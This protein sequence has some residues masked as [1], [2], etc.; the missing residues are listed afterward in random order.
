MRLAAGAGPE[1]D[2]LRL[3]AQCDVEAVTTT[4]FETAMVQACGIAWSG[5]GSPPLAAV[6]ARYDG[7]DAVPGIQRADP[8]W[9]RADPTRV[10]LIGG[11]WLDVSAAE[12]DALVLLLNEH[13]NGDSVSFTRGRN[14]AQWYVS[15][16]PLPAVATASPQRLHGRVL[17]PDLATM[18]GMGELKRVMTEAQMLLHECAVN[19]ERAAAGKPPVTSIWPWGGG[20]LAQPAAGCPHVL[21][22][23]ALSVALAA[24]VGARLHTNP[25]TIPRGAPALVSLPPA[26]PGDASGGH[27]ILA[28]AQRV[29][30]R[31]VLIIDT[32][33]ARF[34]WRRRY[35]WR[36]WRSVTSWRQ[37][38][39]QPAPTEAAS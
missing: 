30:R 23:D 9:L 27:T 22:H 3:L 26:A 32:Q 20:E 33:L 38:F 6:T 13:F 37:R 25:D 4:D 21:G 39:L 17:E 16:L 29:G 14:P 15:G 36:R 24:F 18:Q 5:D 11:E 2:L 19:T 10:R 8:V 34:R 31:D 7:V 28:A 12:A 35:R 1:D